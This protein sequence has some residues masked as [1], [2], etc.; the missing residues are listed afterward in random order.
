MTGRMLGVLVFA[1]VAC[2]G[3]LPM[4]IFADVPTS[5]TYYNEVNMLRE[6]LITQG[7]QASPQ[8]FCPD[9]W[10][11]GYTP[12]F[13]TRGQAATLII[14]SL[15][16]GL[17]VSGIS[18]DPENFTAPEAPYFT[19]VQWDHPQFRYI[20]K[21]KQLGITSGCTATEFCPERELSYGEFSVFVYR[22]RKKKEMNNEGYNVLPPQA[23]T[24]DLFAD[25]LS[26]HPFCAYIRE[27]YYA[28]G[29]DA[30]S[31]ECPYGYFC[32]DVAFNPYGQ[33][34]GGVRV[35]RGTA[36]F[37]L[38]K[39]ILN[40]AYPHMLAT[41]NGQLYTVSSAGP[42]DD[43]QWNGPGMVNM[44]LVAGSQVYGY[45]FTTMSSYSDPDF[46]SF[47]VAPTLKENGTVRYPLAGIHPMQHMTAGTTGAAEVTTPLIALNPA[48]NYEHPVA[49]EIASACWAGGGISASSLP[50]PTLFSANQSVLYRG[51]INR[52][53]FAA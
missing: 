19:D 41:S 11:N 13:L 14:R 3:Q 44:V 2:W 7:C 5:A 20:Q 25:V 51:R 42:P 45:S 15:F 32:P 23:C 29:S 16:S 17:S 38:V 47:V 34:V 27:V 36:S 26:S 48:N 35:K 40:A 1:A 9:Y 37:Y 12:Y 18:G 39:G 30:I 52:C 8:K 31:P 24:Y 21:L 53:R 33:W 28:V 46:W 6:R 50:Y 10:P 43:C 49:H 22:A 4:P